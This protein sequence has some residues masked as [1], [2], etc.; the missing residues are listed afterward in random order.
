MM[1]PPDAS[2]EGWR[3]DRLLDSGIA[4]A[5]VLGAAVLLYLLVAAVAWR[6]RSGRPEP[7][8][9][10]AGATWRGAA[11]TVALTTAVFA[12]LDVRLFAVSTRDL[13]GTFLRADQVDR[14]PR[15]VRV[16][17]NAQRWAWNIRYPGLDGRFA[18]DD[19]VVSMN[20]LRLPV[21]RPVVVEL[22]SSDVVHAFFLPS[23]RVKL[24]AVPGRIQRT[25]FRPTRIG[26]YEIACAEHCGAQHHRMRGTVTV[27]SA[28]D[29]ERWV[30]G[31]SRDAA[32]IAEEDARAIAEEP[33]RAPE[34]GVTP[35]IEDAPNARRWGWPWR[36]GAAR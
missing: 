8:S 26:T 6:A 9:T 18:T 36:G 17:V 11:V 28:G 15:A 13:A 10:A 29:F 25:W 30:A 20:D 12:V 14:D 19:D 27:T 21:D 3:I 35:S 7:R 24:D 5:A 32:R 16:E 31:G 22:A 33:T 2:A 34:P 23:F 4:I 1:R